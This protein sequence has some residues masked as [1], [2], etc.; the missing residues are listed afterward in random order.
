MIPPAC[1]LGFCR[2]LA[3]AGCRLLPPQRPPGAPAQRSA[4]GP[5]KCA[6]FGQRGTH[7]E[8]GEGAAANS[9]R[10]RFARGPRAGASWLPPVDREGP[11]LTCT[12]TPGSLQG[13]AGRLTQKLRSPGAAR[14]GPMPRATL[15]PSPRWPARLPCLHA[16]AG[17]FKPARIPRWRKGVGVR[18]YEPP[19]LQ[20]ARLA[21]TRVLASVERARGARHP[22]QGISIL[23][24]FL[25]RMRP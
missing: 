7:A 5:A 15:L 8:D 9:S 18:P 1:A 14:R 21:T 6:I 13:R 17:L 2:L 25:R 4:Q 16:A 22:P 12:T 23:Q 20:R 3:S 24:R 11:T 10:S 19:S